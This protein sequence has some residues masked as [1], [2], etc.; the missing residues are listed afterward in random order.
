MT[1]YIRK[2][3]SIFNLG[4]HLIF[5]SKNR[6]TYLSRF[7]DDIK[8]FMFI[9]STKIDIIIKDINIMPDHVHIFF[10][11]NRKR[12]VSEIVRYLKGFSSYSIR[13]KF[14]ELKKYKAFWS[15]S[16]FIESVGNMSEKVIRR[17]VNNQN[18]EVKSSYRY[19]HLIK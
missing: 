17:Y 6:K 1:K 3:H 12:S 2:N 7:E 15:P 11:C 19:E 13:N 8:H 16:Y 18:F 9:A 5:S 4:Y 10:K 14:P